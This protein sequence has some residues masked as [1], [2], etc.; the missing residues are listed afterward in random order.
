MTPSHSPSQFVTKGSARCLTLFTMHINTVID[1]HNFGPRLVV[2]LRWGITRCQRETDD[3]FR[4]AGGTWKS[5]EANVKKIMNLK[6][7]IAQMQY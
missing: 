2:S 3:T 1:E 7:V 5:D 6:E 4:K